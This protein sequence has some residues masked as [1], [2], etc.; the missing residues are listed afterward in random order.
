MLPPSTPQVAG[1]Q[2][3]EHLQTRSRGPGR[4]QSQMQAFPQ[5]VSKIPEG[6]V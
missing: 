4:G 6:S 5:E 3:W 1:T 2:C